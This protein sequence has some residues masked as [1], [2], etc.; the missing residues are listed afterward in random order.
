MTLL[1]VIATTVSDARAAE[2][3]GAD[4]LELITAIGEGGLTPSIGLIES[5][6]EAV[7]IS[8]NMIVRPHGRSFVL[9]CRRFRRHVA[10]CAGYCPDACQCDRHRHADFG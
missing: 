3:G 4:R 1:E 7:R 10:R 9:R 5:V 6:V 2:R 8:V